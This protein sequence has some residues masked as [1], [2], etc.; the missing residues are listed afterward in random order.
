MWIYFLLLIL[1]FVILES[2]TARNQKE[3]KLPINLF[4]AFRHIVTRKGLTAED[5][6]ALSGFSFILVSIYLL[7]SAHWAISF[8]PA[9]TADLANPRPS[10][11]LQE[12]DALELKDERVPSK[13]IVA[14]PPIETEKALVPD[15]PL[16]ESEEVVPEILAPAQ[17]TADVEIVAEDD[18]AMNVEET[19]VRTYE[20][21]EF[22]FLAG[23][24]RRDIYQEG[25][26]MSL[27]GGA[28]VVID[29]A[30]SAGKA[31]YAGISG[32]DNGSF[33]ASDPTVIQPA[34]TYE[35]AV[36]MKIS[37]NSVSEDAIRFAVLDAYE[38]EILLE[39]RFRANDFI[40]EGAF[41]TFREKYTR[42]NTGSVQF[43]FYFEDTVDVIID[44]VEVTPIGSVSDPSDNQLIYP[45][46]PDSMAS[47]GQSRLA[48]KGVHI[49]GRI[50]FGPYD[51]NVP[52]G[53]Y[54]ARFYLQSNVTG[55][56]KDIALLDVSSDSEGFKP[57]YA[58][59]EG[60]DFDSSTT[61]KDFDL[62]FEKMNDLGYL[63]FR[64]YSYGTADLKFD[65]V[66]LY[67]VFDN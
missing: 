9:V 67:R 15:L 5:T 28:K 51:R 20:E 60:N 18:K 62:S 30:A 22:A 34:G 52:A 58:V 48:K 54:L 13:N 23:Q 56:D 33:L 42:D 66:D 65:R 40:Q 64:I 4:W 41:K 24:S 17:K 37:D 38:K 31:V 8:G 35:V 10:T 1:C 45:D 6:I 32:M 11:L 57:S 14:S 39:R 55:I 50:A 19:F 29:E 53:K 3:Q 36:T 59:L 26:E 61:F 2:V 7:A 12:E 46:V 43:R 47:G 49:P 16:V 63:E 27:L 44:R 21:S 25:E